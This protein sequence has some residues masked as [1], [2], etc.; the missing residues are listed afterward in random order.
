MVRNYAHVEVQVFR[1]RHDR[2]DAR[3]RDQ[4]FRHSELAETQPGLELGRLGVAGTI[5]L[6]VIQKLDDHPNID[7]GQLRV[8]DFVHDQNELVFRAETG[9]RSSVVDQDDAGGRYD[10]SQNKGS[11]VHDTKADGSVQP[12]ADHT[13]YCI[14][15]GVGRVQAEG[16]N[17]SRQ[18]S[19]VQE[20]ESN[21]DSLPDHRIER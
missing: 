17:S 5:L 13:L 2:L 1:H 16:T 7:Y 10:W 18:R 21:D 12:A 19:H 11:W 9:I 6:G 4:V 8:L 3:S 20:T 15:H 14:L